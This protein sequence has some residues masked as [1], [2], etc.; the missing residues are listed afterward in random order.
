MQLFASQLVGRI[1]VVISESV[2]CVW[3]IACDWVAGEVCR[4]ALQL[5][6][7]IALEAG[8]SLEVFQLGAERTSVLVPTLRLVL[9]VTFLLVGLLQAHCVRAFALVQLASHDGD[10]I[11]NLLLLDRIITSLLLDLQVNLALVV[12]GVLGLICH[13]SSNHTS[14]S[15]SSCR[16]ALEYTRGALRL[17]EETPVFATGRDFLVKISG[18]ALHGHFSEEAPLKNTF[19]IGL[20]LFPSLVLQ[21]LCVLLLFAAHCLRRHVLV[22]PLTWRSLVWSIQ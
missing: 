13:F 17:A 7:A 12:G 18:A 22:A 15:R 21:E 9:G 3:E 5:H 6:F 1:C 11:E 16:L 2:W 4:Q 20:G 10:V 8:R 19:D 14:E